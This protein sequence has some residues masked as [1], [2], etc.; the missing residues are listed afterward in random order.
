[1]TSTGGGAQS[2]AGPPPS[3][4]SQRIVESADVVYRSATVNTDP[5]ARSLAS[6]GQ[7]AEKGGPER[8]FPAFL[9]PEAKRTL[10]RTTDGEGG[11]LEN[12]Q[13]ELTTGFPGPCTLVVHLV[14]PRFACGAIKTG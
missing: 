9:T 12:K 8:L 11:K 10:L 5:P 2:E 14:A 3:E 7:L 1:L 4:T 13:S 6:T